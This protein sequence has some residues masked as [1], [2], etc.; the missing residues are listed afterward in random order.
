M[1]HQ[2]SSSLVK[3]VNVIVA[4][5]E[6]SVTNIDAAP[7]FAS[8]VAFVAIVVIVANALRINY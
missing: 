4:F 8:T 3:I 5:V 7:Y 1:C 2:L 6:Q